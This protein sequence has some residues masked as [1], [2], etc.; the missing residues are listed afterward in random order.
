[1]STHGSASVTNLAGRQSS[2]VV[3]LYR[4]RP[5]CKPFILSPLLQLLLDESSRRLPACRRGGGVAKAGGLPGV[6]DGGVP[7]Q[8]REQGEDVAEAMVPGRWYDF[9][10][11]SAAGERL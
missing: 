8:A 7:V 11:W 3:L 2:M 5:H 10:G 6:D 4:L 9:L 1:V